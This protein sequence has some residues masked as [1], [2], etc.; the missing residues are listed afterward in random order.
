MGDFISQADTLVVSQNIEDL[1]MEGILHTT[2]LS[3][4]ISIVIHIDSQPNE[5]WAA[6]NVEA[7]THILNESSSNCTE[8]LDIIR[9][10][11]LLYESYFDENDSGPKIRLILNNDTTTGFVSLQRVIEL[12]SNN[13]TGKQSQEDVQESVERNKSLVPSFITMCA[14]ATLIMVL[15]IRMWPS[16]TS[17]RGYQTVP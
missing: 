11:L 5:F 8:W 16:S 7:C 12:E 6:T 1:V 3:H 14:I 13:I 2:P 9:V 17:R 4:L 15:I 10:P